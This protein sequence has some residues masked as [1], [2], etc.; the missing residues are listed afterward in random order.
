MALI[1]FIS[2]LL[3]FLAIP[4][5]GNGPFNNAGGMFSFF[6]TV[7]LMSLVFPLVLFGAVAGSRVPGGV[8]FC[9]GLTHLRRG[10]I[11]PASD[12]RMQPH[13]SLRFLAGASAVSLAAWGIGLLLWLNRLVA[14]REAEWGFVIA[15]LVVQLLIP[16]AWY[17]WFVGRFAE[18]WR[19]D[20]KSEEPSELPPELPTE[21][22]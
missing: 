7:V 11:L 13:I 4:E 21:Q 20:P 14:N 5:W 8:Y 16:V 10:Q 19:S 2:S 3:I 15:L 12:R 9:T 18:R 17:L 1:L 22:D 6:Q